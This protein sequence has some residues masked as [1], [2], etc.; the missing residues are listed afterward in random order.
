[1]IHTAEGEFFREAIRH[2]SEACRLPVTGIREREIHSAGAAEFGL[3]LETI[4]R[5]VLELGRS[6]GPPWR[7]D[8]KLA[9]LAGWLTLARA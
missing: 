2:A 6:I 9:A 7:Q 8:E 4:Q 1:M 3:P 5:R